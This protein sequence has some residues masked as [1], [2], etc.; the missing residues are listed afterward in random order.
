MNIR[1]LEETVNFFH[2]EMSS[3]LWAL[4]EYSNI[5]MSNAIGEY[6]YISNFNYHVP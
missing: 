5:L 3:R 1:G 4:L 6:R 2:D